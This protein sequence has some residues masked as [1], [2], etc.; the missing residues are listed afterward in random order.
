VK[1]DGGVQ[2]IL[3]LCLSNFNGCNVGISNGRD[4]GIASFRRAKMA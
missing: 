4:L 3:M 1:I 2:A